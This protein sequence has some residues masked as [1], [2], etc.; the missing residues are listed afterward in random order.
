MGPIWHTVPCLCGNEKICL[1]KYEQTIQITK[2]RIDSKYLVIGVLEQLKGTLGV[3]EKLLP[4]FFAGA[5]NQLGLIKNDTYTVKK[6]EL[7]E[8]AR[9]YL[10]EQTTLKLE[11]DLY[12][13]VRTR[14]LEQMRRLD[15]S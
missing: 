10:A 13:H 5:V 1:K 4:D 12:Y 8:A 11:Y 9:D 14:L 2:Q 15:I 3:L 7:S 6:K